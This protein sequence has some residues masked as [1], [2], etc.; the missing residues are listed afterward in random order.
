M[1]RKNW[2]YLDEF[3]RKH[4]QLLGAIERRIQRSFQGLHLATSQV[5]EGVPFDSID[6][7]TGFDLSRF[8]YIE[9]QIDALT[10][11]T[12]K[13]ILKTIQEAVRSTYAISTAK[14]IEM[15]TKYIGTD[16][17]QLYID[18]LQRAGSATAF[19]KQW[20]DN[21]PIS[22]RVWNIADQFKREV[23]DR[24]TTDLLNGVPADEV[25][26]NIRGFL[27]EPNR[28]Y[29]RVRGADGVLRLSKNARAYHPG[30]GVYRSSYKNARRLA[31]TEVNNAYRK[32][33]SDRWQQLDF[34]IG[35]RVQ[36]SNNHTYRD[37][38]GRLRTLVDICDDLKGDYP[39]DFV[40]TSWHPHCRCIATPILK[41]RAEMKADRE[42]ILRGEEPTPSQHEIKEMPANFKQWQKANASRIQGAMERDTLP[43]WYRDNQAVI[44]GVQVDTTEAAHEVGTPYPNEWRQ[45]NLARAKARHEARTE[46][47]V[48]NVQ[49]KWDTREV[50]N[51]IDKADA[52]IDGA[53]NKWFR[54]EPVTYVRD[55][56]GNPVA[57]SLG[58]VVN[59]TVETNPRN[60]GSTNMM[61]TI[62]LRKERINKSASAIR[63]IKNGQWHA[64]DEDEADAMATLWHEITHN[65]NL[66][67]K[68]DKTLRITNTQ[69]RAM[70]MVNE[71]VARK[72]LPEFYGRL[73]AKGVPHPEFMDSRKS[74]GYNPMVR[75]FDHLIDV[76]KLNRSEVLKTAKSGLYD[77]D[78]SKQLEN[79]TNALLNAGIQDFETANKKKIGKR[80]VNKLVSLCRDAP[81]P[82]EFAI[83]KI[84]EYLLSEGIIK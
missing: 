24:I 13:E 43:H 76:F 14:A 70:E 56:N 69:R 71:F 32:A 51:T 61:G 33:D 35:V 45:K 72:T 37:H 10:E 3:E 50:R 34:V 41:S 21:H 64:I 55:N 81:H 15:T 53:E 57:K 82:E 8:P 75:S 6:L 40:F 54:N 11:R 67:N 42:R 5:L 59:I 68:A 66:L 28:L 49:L 1:A 25:S 47:H 23:G 63:K 36:L 80:Q 73:G 18:T 22:E 46:K 52:G 83:K 7:A 44:G 62:H 84:D 60:N 48:E 9:A 17:S 12:Q 20:F 30:Q 26:R 16:A 74:T 39:K 27:N 78:Y 29:R 58:R 38:K 65:R 4:R 79:A 2:T 77:G 19:Q 31:V